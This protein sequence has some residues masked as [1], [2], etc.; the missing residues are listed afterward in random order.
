MNFHLCLSM[1][2]FVCAKAAAGP[3]MVQDDFESGMSQW[4]ADPPERIAIIP[5]EGTSNHVL[6]L[7]PERREFTQVML[8]G[9][10]TFTNVRVE[11]RFLFPTDGDGY[12]GFIYNHQ[13]DDRRT[14]SG[15]IYVKSNGSYLR[16]SPH[17]DGNPS[18]RLYEEF[19]VDLEGDRRIRTRTWYPFR[20]E[21]SGHVATLAIGDLEHPL[22]RFRGA[23][24][25][26][27]ALGLEARPGGGEPVWVDDI[28]VS[29]L[30]TANAIAPRGTPSAWEILGPFQPG[31]PGFH[32]A[33]ELPQDGWT[34]L[35]LDQRGALITGRYTQYRSGDKDWVYLRHRFQTMDPKSGPRWLAASS[36]N[37]LDVWL[38]GYFRGTVAEERFIWSD[39]LTSTEHP[40]AR[41]PIDPTVGSNEIIIRVHGRRFAGGGMFLSLL[42]RQAPDSR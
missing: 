11:G 4:H 17:F 42:P 30:S 15:V 20:L 38:N 3:V 6:R 5:E 35:T 2:L 40:G 22:V 36:A 13:Q 37:R 33:P 29:R 8:A 14:D 26:L 34:P 1:M 18:W 28:I 39:F 9:S 19:R 7:T 10:S 31:D 16:I 25:A 27:G 21:V 23:P 32:E 41:V 24:A 12:L